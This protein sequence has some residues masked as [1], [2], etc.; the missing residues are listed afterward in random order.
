MQG[1]F[2][3]VELPLIDQVQ[4]QIERAFEIP[5]SDSETGGL[6][7]GLSVGRHVR[8]DRIR[9]DFDR[10]FLRCNQFH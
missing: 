1:D 3:D 9:L 10:I 8:V 7:C 5:E 4:Q 6:G 2:G